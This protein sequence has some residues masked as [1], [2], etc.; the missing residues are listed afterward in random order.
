[1]ILA[2]SRQFSSKTGEGIY[3]ARAAFAAG[4]E[5]IEEIKSQLEN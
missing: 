5:L 1:M 3:E 4:I 2:C